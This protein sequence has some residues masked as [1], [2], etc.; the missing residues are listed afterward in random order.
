MQLAKKLQQERLV[1]LSSDRLRRLLK[2]NYRWKRTRSS[3]RRKQDPVKKAIKQ[4]D[5]DTLKLA[6]QQ[7]YIELKYLDEAFF[8]PLESS[9]LQL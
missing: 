7:G 1:D 5:L 9:Q 4:A 6:A 3:H 2:K 8:L